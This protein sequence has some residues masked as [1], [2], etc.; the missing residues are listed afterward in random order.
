MGTVYLAETEY[1]VAGLEPGTQVAIKV[2]HPH[3][4]GEEQFFE[5]FQREAEVGLSI[6]HDNVVKTFESSSAVAG[7][8]TVH[9]LAMEFVQGQTL[10]ELLEEM[11]RVPEDLCRHIGREVS[12]ALVAVHSVGVVHRDIK[13]ENILITGEQV[14]KVMDLG[15]ARLQ[16]Q[17]MRL[18]TAGQFIGSMLYAAPEQVQSAGNELD[19]RADLYALGW[20]LY[21]LAAGRHAFRDD[22]ITVLLRRQLQDN[23]PRLGELNPQLSPLFEETVACL[24]KKDRTERF[25]ASHELLEVFTDGEKS[26]WWRQRAIEIRAATR[27]PLRRVRIPRETALY[28]RDDNLA[29][30]DALWTRAKTGVGQALIVEGEAGIG[31]TRL[32]DEFVGRQQRDGDDLNFL[33]GSY[34]PGGAATSTGAFSDAYREQFGAEGLQETL[35]SYLP[36]VKP[37]LPA[38]AALLKGELP[39]EGQEKLTKESTQTLFSH[40]TRALAAERPTIVVIDDL[41]FSPDEGRALFAAL[42]MA[43]RTQ[44]V[45]L[46]GTVRPGAAEEW[47]A[48]LARLPHV[49]RMA[50]ER[51]GPSDLGK[52]LREALGSGAETLA[53]KVATKSDGNPFFVFE[54]L[55]VLRE[56]RVLAE[57]AG[58]SGVSSPRFAEI[59]IP[60]TVSD[61]MGGRLAQLD[62]DERELLDVAACCG[63]EFDP[64]LVGETLEMKRIATLKMFARLEEQR[65][66]VRCVGERYVFDHHQ[67]QEILYSRLPAPLAREYHAALAEALEEMAEADE[68]APEELDGK[69]LVELTAHYLKGGKARSAKPYLAAALD[70]LEKGYRHAR[71]AE[72]AER[73]LASKKA[74]KGTE[75]VEMLLRRASSLNVIGRHDDEK[76]TLAEA[77]ALADEEGAHTLRAKS[78]RALGSA[79]VST[80]EYDEGRD[81][82]DQ[83]LAITRES[84]NREDEAGALGSI[85]TILHLRGRYEE[86]HE[87]HVG[88]LEIAREL[89]DRRGETASSINAGL[90]LIA[91]A[92]YDD[93]RAIL[94]RG[95]EL[96]REIG[97]RRA[98]ARVSA[99]LGAIFWMLGNYDRTRELWERQLTIAR[100]IGDR[101]AEARATLNLGHVYSS[102]RSYAETQQSTECTLQIAREIGNRQS[103]TLALLALTDLYT[104]LGNITLAKKTLGQTRAVLETIGAKRLEGYV[105]QAEALLAERSRRPDDAERLYNDALALR[106]SIKYRSGEAESLLALG[107]LHLAQGRKE[108]AREHLEAALALGSELSNTSV[109]VHAT[110]YLALLEGKRPE[111]AIKAIKALEKHESRLSVAHRIEAHFV[112][113]KTTRDREHVDTAR[114]LLLDSRASAPREYRESMVSSVPLHDDVLREAGPGARHEPSA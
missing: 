83:A 77:V 18:S 73:A 36:G 47:A 63:F 23:P 19:G 90:A 79:H 101:R 51:L 12:K 59:E 111:A 95:L 97:D 103:E 65:Q 11:G 98:E 110:A 62:E 14:V 22:D 104:T 1:G 6:H 25:Q 31:K 40:A 39:P 24:L 108:R 32:V 57:K 75:R 61:L 55:R 109:I 94:E 38:F 37:L 87:K 44:P 67:I 30:L 4:L 28:G 41:H 86:A 99:N 114:R 88:H 10:R 76:A 34:P 92:R 106:R 105:L 112:L 107:R 8:D 89:G 82:L 54:I 70:R 53:G 66:L 29:Q 2:V 93:A 33:F 7:G 81:W 43:L 13:P 102:I 15:C 60:S 27:R 58:G 78:R 35:S 72:M 16:D 74:Y 84:G 5:R 46:V 96:A 91:L 85:G 42:A 80:S 49:E 64:T 50:V 56:Q 68:D 17:A 45:L 48:E 21:E 113:W 26:L 71:A 100:E 69:V 20:V 52:L 9:Y 3:L